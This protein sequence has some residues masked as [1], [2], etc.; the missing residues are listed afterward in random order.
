[1]PG[2]RAP[3]KLLLRRAGLGDAERVADVWLRSRK[4][5]VPAIPPAVHSDEEVR[6][7]LAN[8]V[9]PTKDV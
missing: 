7:W 9:L 6:D 1:M 2:E 8:V 5:T 4:A 3:S